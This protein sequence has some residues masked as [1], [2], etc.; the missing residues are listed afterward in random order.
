MNAL[1]L[2]A[3]LLLL[4][5]PPYSASKLSELVELA[6][7][8]TA[9]C[10]VADFARLELVAGAIAAGDSAAALELAARL[11]PVRGDCGCWLRAAL[12]E[13]CG[14]FE[15]AAG[16]LHFLREKTAGEER[17]MAMLAS[18]RNFHAAERP[19]QVWYPLAEACKSSARP[20]TLRNAARLLAQARKKAEPPF[21]RRCRIALLSST[22]ID[23]LA[24]ILQ[25]QC[26]SAGI[27]A[28]I[29]VGPFNQIEQE[30][31]DPESGMARFR[32]DVIAI[33]TDWRS[34]GLRDE[35]DAP[36]E[37]VREHVARL[38]SLWRE[39]QRALRTQ[40][41]FSSTMRRRRLKPSDT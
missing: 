31:R 5:E 22:T 18:A 39:A 38:E 21:R 15:E 19:D 17:A 23:F 25:A 30:I 14:H 33:A 20:R 24:P 8:Y 16:A 32:P 10:S 37:I 11:E 12:L 6:G 9:V 13:A 2:E 1:P 4:G 28:D 27:D 41:R 7:S 26:F 36:D 40:P 29:Y 34:L 35:E 3:N